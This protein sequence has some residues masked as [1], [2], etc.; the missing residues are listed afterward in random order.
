MNKSN[1]FL[2]DAGIA[3]GLAV[4]LLLV[5]ALDKLIPGP[6]RATSNPLITITNSNKASGESKPLKLAVTP[7]QDDKK[8]GKWD[9]MPR[10][11]DFLGTGFPYTMYPIQD[12]RDDKKLEKY[13]V[14]FL[15]CARGQPEPSYTSNLRDFVRKGGTLYASDW[16]YEWVA[17]AFPDVTALHLLGNGR[18][19]WVTAKVVDPGLRDILGPSIRLY[20]NLSLWK[21]AAFAGRR[22]KVLLEAE[23]EKDEKDGGGT[24][25]APLLVE[26][27][28]GKGT[29]IFTSFHNEKKNYD[30]EKKLLKYLVFSAI[31]AKT[32]TQV[33]QTM[34]KG[35][36]S[37]QKSNLLS[38]SS[39]NKIEQTYHSKKGG[40]I[41][42]VLGFEDRG[43]TLK[44]TVVGP[45]G[46]TY[47]Q[48]GNSTISIDVVNAQAGDYR[49]TV[50]ALSVP[51]PDFPFTLT[52]G[53]SD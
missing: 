14:L 20:F 46:K 35:G 29:V 33:T 40:K 51:H 43:A 38:A 41:R 16:R 4:A 32:Q 37:P 11:L 45:D 3:A 42:F 49:Y 31:T 26:F 17:Q 21:T 12:L 27:Q 34:I 28:S 47:E 25:V 44:L 2:L 52:V 23:Y 24:A 9:D 50:T 19:G 13:D 53:E 22:V 8:N 30:V 1:T 6:A 48:T 18:A 10:F 5:I 39:D 15:T 36:F 7:T